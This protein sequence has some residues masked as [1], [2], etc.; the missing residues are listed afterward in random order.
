[1]G[2]TGLWKSQVSEI[3]GKVWSKEDLLSVEKDQVREHL[4]KWSTHKSV[5]LNGVQPQVL[6]E[7]FYVLERPLSIT[8]KRT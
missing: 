4:N 8:F 1:M 6:R 5:R 2:K 3:S 7:S